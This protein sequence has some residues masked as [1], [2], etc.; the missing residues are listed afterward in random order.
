MATISERYDALK[1]KQGPQELLLMRMGD[2]LEAFD[3]DAL[4]VGKLLGISVT[5]RGVRLMAGF[6]Y[7]HQDKNVAKLVEAGYRVSVADPF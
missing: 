1:Q 7:F 2:F 3:D 4:I 6:P 5:N